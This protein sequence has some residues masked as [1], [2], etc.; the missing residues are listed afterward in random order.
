VLKAAKEAGLS[1]AGQE[2]TE[3]EANMHSSPV[4]AELKAVRNIHPSFHKGFHFF[5][6]YSALDLFV[7][8]GSAPF[9]WHND[10]PDSEKTR[11]AKE[12]VIIITSQQVLFDTR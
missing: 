7:L 10:K 11:P 5:L 3:Y 6:G 12:V 2:V 9:T 4:M 1:L 8:K